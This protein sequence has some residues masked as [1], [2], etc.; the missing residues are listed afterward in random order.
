MS[1]I[2][3]NLITWSIYTVSA[4]RFFKIHLNFQDVAFYHRASEVISMKPMLL[5]NRCHRLHQQ[6]HRLSPSV[7]FLVFITSR[8]HIWFV[9][10]YT[11]SIFFLFAVLT[12]IIILVTR[13]IGEQLLGL[14]MTKRARIR[15]WGCF[16]TC[17]CM[18]RC[19]SA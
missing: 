12:L 15:C 5:L 11:K 2:L 19:P 3:I 6:Q 14:V 1:L 17:I 9:F 7:K 4:Q 16:S 10:E 8:V 18:W 13:Q